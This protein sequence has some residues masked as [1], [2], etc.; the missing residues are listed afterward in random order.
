MAILAILVCTVIAMSYYAEH[1]K[2]AYE[3]HAG[4]G[5]PVV[6]PVTKSDA[7]KDAHESGYPPS[8]IDAFAWPEGATA[9]FLLFTLFVVAWQSGETR[10]AAK[11]S[12][13]S[14]EAALRQ[15]DHMVASDRAWLII[16]SENAGGSVPWSGVP[17]P[18][19]WIVKNVGNTPAILLE[20]QA[21]C[22]V[23]D[24]IRLPDLPQG[25]ESIVLNKRIL[26]PNDTLEL[27]TFWTAEDG[28]M[29][30]GDLETITIPILIAYGFVKYRTVFDAQTEVH[31]SRFCDS[32]ICNGDP[33]RMHPP[34][35]IEFKPMLEA[36]PDY[37]KHT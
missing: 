37:T 16:T 7:G 17:P 34:P 21:V 26:A 28:R 10:S 24:S 4:P 15:A 29:F 30:R 2:E 33:T 14:A 3:R 32:W 22:K 6:V 13:K 1:R 5:N 8:W 36:P 18:Y 12:K 27:N 9:W 19:W 31:E 20:S 23:A 35:V 11:A 25:P